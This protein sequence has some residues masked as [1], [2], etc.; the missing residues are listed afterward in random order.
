M[1]WPEGKEN[2]SGGSKVAQQWGS[3]AHGRLRAHRRFSLRN[4]AMPTPA[5]DVAAPSARN[6]SGPPNRATTKPMAYH[7]HPSP[8]RV[9]AI[10]HIRIQRGGRQRF[11]VRIRRFSPVSSQCT[12]ERTARGVRMMNSRVIIAPQRASEISVDKETAML[13]F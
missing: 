10:I 9:A 12:P 1:V 6:R 3:I 7:S 2:W 8:P 4:N 13:H 11:T 5:D